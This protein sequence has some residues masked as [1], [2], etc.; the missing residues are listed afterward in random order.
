MAELIALSKPI[1]SEEQMRILL[2]DQEK[3]QLALSKSGKIIDK[4]KS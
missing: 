1:I 2:R 4:L 3:I